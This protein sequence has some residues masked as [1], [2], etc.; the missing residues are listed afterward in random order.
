MYSPAAIALF[1]A[2]EGGLRPGQPAQSRR[3][4]RP[5]A[6]RRRS[7][8]GGAGRPPADR[9][10]AEVHR[11]IGRRQVPG[12][13][14]RQ[15]RR[16]VP[17]VP[18]HPGREGLHPRPGP[19]AAGDDQRRPGPAGLEVAGRALGP[20]SLPVLQ[21]MR[22]GLPDRDRHGGVQVGGAGS[23]LRAASCGRARTTRW[24]GCRAGDG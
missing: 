15:P 14:H 10:S 18:G 7:A 16:D 9:F 23:H 3:A 4:G 5:A 22:A 17:V 6:G 8:G 20:G 19:G 12:R 21:G 13:Q 2:G 1:G 11:C 24:A